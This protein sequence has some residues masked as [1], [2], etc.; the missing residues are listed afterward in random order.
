MSPFP[1][2]C[3]DLRCIQQPLRAMELLFRAIA[4]GLGLHS[5]SFSQLPMRFGL[6]S[7]AP[8]FAQFPLVLPSAARS[9]ASRFSADEVCT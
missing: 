7:L 4:L 5:V 3:G 8:P 9:P 2:G 1:L 6:L